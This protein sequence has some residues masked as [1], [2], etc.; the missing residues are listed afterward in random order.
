MA[1]RPARINRT[2]RA[3]FAERRAAMHRGDATGLA[4]SSPA[5]ARRDATG[6]R[7][8]SGPV[9]ALRPPALPG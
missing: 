4:R 6:A 8:D 9:D 2:A 5:R 3:V 7:D 1:T